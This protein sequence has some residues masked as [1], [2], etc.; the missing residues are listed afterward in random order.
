MFA[1]TPFRPIVTPQQV[2]APQKKLW[3]D[4][5]EE[6]EQE[7]EEQR[8]KASKKNLFGQFCEVANGN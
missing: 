5:V 3:A 6:E 7:Q 2:M 4:I 1:S 8:K